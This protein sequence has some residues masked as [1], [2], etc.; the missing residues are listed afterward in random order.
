MNNNNCSSPAEQLRR[1]AEQL[2]RMA[3]AFANCECRSESCNSQADD[4]AA[5]CPCDEA[6]AYAVEEEAAACTAAP[7]EKQAAD[8]ADTNAESADSADDGEQTDSQAAEESCADSEEQAEKVTAKPMNSKQIGGGLF[9]AMNGFNMKNM[10][11][12]GNL[13]GGLLGGAGGLGGLGGLG[14]LGG[15]AGLGDA[16]KSVEELKNNPQLMSVLGSLESNPTLLN[17]I[18]GLSGMD[19]DQILSSIKALQGNVETSAATGTEASA[20]T[21]ADTAA[22]AD[23]SQAAANPLG[24]LNLNSLNDLSRL[25]GGQS[26][27]QGTG[28]AQAAAAPMGQ[29]GMMQNMSAGMQTMPLRG[30]IGGDPL[31]NLL[32][33]WHWHPLR[34]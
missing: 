12:L 8:S 29:S 33:Q 5:G 10:P 18:A 34:S 30:T 6:V 21:A 17:T 7:G 14:N 22:A 20:D 28:Q 13:F 24:N 4:N 16:P 31:M 23:S 9:G 3:D 1:M 19:K 26:A 11:G 25:F 27:P 15:L 2:T 32:N